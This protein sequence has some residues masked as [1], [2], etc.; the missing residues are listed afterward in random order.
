MRSLLKIVLFSLFISLIC[1]PA[2]AVVKGPVRLSIDV[3]PGQWKTARLK[4][5]PKDAVV[6]VKVECD[7]EVAVF[8]AG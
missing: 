4:S 8:K 5:L 1:L 3:P 2:R 7:G 6:A